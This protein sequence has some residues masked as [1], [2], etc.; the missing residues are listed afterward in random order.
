MKISG[1]VKSVIFKNV[2]NGYCVIE[3]ETL[4]KSVICTGKFPIIGEAEI[5]V[6]RLLRDD[7]GYGG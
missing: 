5:L 6:S 1:S 4:G 2:E 3:L 7:D